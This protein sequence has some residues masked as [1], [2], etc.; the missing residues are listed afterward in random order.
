MTSRTSVF[1][2]IVEGQTAIVGYGKMGRMI[3]ELAG[4]RADVVGRY[5]GG[6]TAADVAVDFHGGR[7]SPTS[8]NTSRGGCPR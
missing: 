6:G 4:H 7:A 8:I 1:P 3:E 5:E 2:T